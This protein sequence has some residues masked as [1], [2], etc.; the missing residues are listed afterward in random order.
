V[1]I[2]KYLDEIKLYFYKKN[3]YNLFI[4]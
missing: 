3:Y 4:N 1:R 2:N